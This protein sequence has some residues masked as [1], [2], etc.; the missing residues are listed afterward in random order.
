MGNCIALCVSSC[1]QCVPKSLLC[2]RASATG[3]MER[4]AASYAD[5]FVRRYFTEFLEKYLRKMSKL[6][7]K[8]RLPSLEQFVCKNEKVILHC[9]TDGLCAAEFQKRQAY[10]FSHVNED[11]LHDLKR[12]AA[13]EL[14]KQLSCNEENSELMQSMSFVGT[15]ALEK[16]RKQ[17]QLAAANVTLSHEVS[18]QI[19]HEIVKFAFGLRG[20]LNAGAS[21]ATTKLKEYWA[22]RTPPLLFLMAITLSARMYLDLTGAGKKTDTELGFIFFITGFGVFAAFAMVYLRLPH[23]VDGACFQKASDFYTARKVGLA[24]LVN[25]AACQS[26]EQNVSFYGRQQDECFQATTL[27]LSAA[28]SHAFA[29]S[30][31]AAPTHAIT[32]HDDDDDTDVTVDEDSRMAQPNQGRSGQYLDVNKSGQYRFPNDLHVGTVV[33]SA[34]S[35]ISASAVENRKPVANVPFGE[36][37]DSKGKP[38]A[39]LRVQP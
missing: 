36:E 11:R 2:C 35:T 21:V 28:F 37:M 23:A 31:V 7:K 18:S 24:Q 34:G 19:I 17:Q 15:K 22:N 38:H 10:L 26:L 32:V 20:E 1:I 3:V 12:F 6:A 33:R 13:S 29:E 39:E 27:R 9:L 30:A 5:H 25:E 4:H 16:A 14:M 8:N